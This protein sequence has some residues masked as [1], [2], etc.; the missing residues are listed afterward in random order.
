[1]EQV[2]SLLIPPDIFAFVILKDDV[3]T[4]EEEII[5][6]LQQLIRTQIGGFAV[7]HA[8]SFLVSSCCLVTKGHFHLSNYIGS[9]R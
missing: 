3:T 7:P 9:D 6:Q 4:S 1:M 5:K 8:Q 2:N